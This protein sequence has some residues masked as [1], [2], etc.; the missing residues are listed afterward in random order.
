MSAAYPSGASPFLLG[1]GLKFVIGFSTLFREFEV[2]SD[3][4]FILVFSSFL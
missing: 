1:A 4:W 3:F 2:D